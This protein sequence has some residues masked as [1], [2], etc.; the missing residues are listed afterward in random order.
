[1]GALNKKRGFKIYQQKVRWGHSHRNKKRKIMRKIISFITLILLMS[2][3]NSQRKKTLIGATEYQQKLN[4]SYKDG[5]KSPLKKNDLKNFKGL[6]FYPVDSSFIVTA[7]LT[8]TKDATTFEMATTTDRKPLYKEYGILTFTLK[9]IDCSLTVYQ[10]QDDLRDEKYKDFLFLP[11]T[12]NSSGNGSYA[13]GRYMDVMTTD[14]KTDGT[15]VLNF[16]NSYN[17][18][19]AYNE[20]Y[21]CPLTP[22][23]NHLS[24]AVKAGIK[25]FKK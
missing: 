24:L 9:G 15:I 13:G 7:R 25:D 14:E 4:E 11:F 8:K 3:C 2:A 10:S 12:D 19:C 18:Y 21:S 23:Q 17:P 6:E 5:S 1:L 16:N 20:K 22:R